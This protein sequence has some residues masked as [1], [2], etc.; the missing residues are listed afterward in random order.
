[1]TTKLVRVPAALAD[2]M[3]TV[4][5]Y[6]VVAETTIDNAQSEVIPLAEATTAVE[7]EQQMPE[8]WTV[9]GV[10]KLATDNQS[11]ELMGKIREKV[12]TP[13]SVE[14]VSDLDQEGLNEL[15]AF[16]QSFVAAS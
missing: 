4:G 3:Q 10:L 15:A 1:M 5:G 14:K 16:I 6:D 12:L 9:E 8:Q 11:A 13:R 2:L 7:P